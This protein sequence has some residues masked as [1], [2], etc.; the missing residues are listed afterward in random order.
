MPAGLRTR[1]A[2]NV[3][4][5]TLTSRATRLL[6]YME[7]ASAG[8]V[9][10]PEL[11]EGTPFVFPVLDQNGIMYP[12]NFMLPTVSGTTLSWSGPGRFYYGTF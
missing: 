8:S 11:A 3:V 7:P 2:A 5:L 4:E 6:G 9:V 10:I 12:S 1:S